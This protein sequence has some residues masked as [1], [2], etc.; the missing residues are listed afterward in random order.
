MPG[1]F[2][3]YDDATGNWKRNP[4]MMFIHKDESMRITGA[5]FRKITN[6]GSRFSARGKLGFYILETECSES[7]YKKTV[8]LVES[9][10]SANSLWEFLKRKNRP[11]IV[12]STGGVSLVPDELPKAYKDLPKKLI[13]DYDGN[14]TLYNDRLKLYSH[15]GAKPI[16]LILPK[17]EDIN[18]LFNLNKIDLI[19]YLLD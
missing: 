13:I 10:T 8:F 15:L 12:I 17:G 18:S 4:A 2:F 1:V 5:K 6:D 14:E 19:E 16:K 3:T 11:A 9:E 7:F